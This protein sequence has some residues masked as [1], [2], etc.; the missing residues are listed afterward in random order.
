MVNNWSCQKIEKLQVKKRCSVITYPLL[1]LQLHSQSHCSHRLLQTK[2]TSLKPNFHIQKC[3]T[4]W[5]S[6]G[7]PTFQHHHLSPSL[8]QHNDRS[9]AD[10]SSQSALQRCCWFLVQPVGKKLWL[11]VR[12]TLRHDMVPQGWDQNNLYS[13]SGILGKETHMQLEN[14]HSNTH[15]WYSAAGAAVGIPR[16]P[17]SVFRPGGGGGR[18]ELGWRWNTPAAGAVG[19][20]VG[21]PQVQQLEA[22]GWILSEK[23]GPRSL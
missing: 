3:E 11:S 15:R 12:E 8:S 22:P 6:F 16:Q 1:F 10:V 2:V 20:L 17:G 19:R 5:F 13:S 21:S 7:W 9:C 18:A 14:M 23:A 4:S